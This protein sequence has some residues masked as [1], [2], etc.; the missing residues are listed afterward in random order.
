M[1]GCI[2]PMSSPMM[3]RMLGLDCCGA[4]AKLGTLAIDASKSEAANVPIRRRLNGGRDINLLL[5]IKV[6]RSVKSPCA[7]VCGPLSARLVDLLAALN[8]R[9][10]VSV[11][12]KVHLRRQSWAVE[13]GDC[14]AG[15]R[16]KSCV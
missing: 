16:L 2:Q 7:T 9:P 12:M 14:K 13:A 6:L 15:L 4:C 3:N 1:L 11:R 10:D 8:Q 5:D